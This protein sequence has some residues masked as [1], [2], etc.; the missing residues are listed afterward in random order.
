[1]G[2]SSEID[3]NVVHMYSHLGEKLLRTTYN[4]LGVKLTGTLQVC[5]G[6]ARSKPKSRAVRK[7]TYKRVLKPGERIFVV[8]TIPFLES[9]IGNWY[10]IGVID[11]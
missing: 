7:K 11:N 3:I 6:C 9:L 2:L 1:M 8:P 4:A 5:D 10:W